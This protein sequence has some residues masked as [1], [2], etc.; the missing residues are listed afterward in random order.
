MEGWTK[1]SPFSSDPLIGI[2]NLEESDEFNDILALLNNIKNEEEEPC[3]NNL[4]KRNEDLRNNIEQ[5]LKKLNIKASH[6]DREKFEQMK[7]SKIQEN[8]NTQEKISKY[9]SIIKVGNISVSRAKKAIENS[10]TIINCLYQIMK[11]NNCVTER[12]DELH[13]EI[14]KK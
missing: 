2:G 3:Y 14:L 7:N 1:E 6:F 13:Q 4:T 12:A 11:E 9:N 8:E 5:E 10:D